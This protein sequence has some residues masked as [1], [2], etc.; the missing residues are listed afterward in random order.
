MQNV[1]RKCPVALAVLLLSAGAVSAQTSKALLRSGAEEYLTLKRTFQKMVET[2][3]IKVSPVRYQGAVDLMDCALGHTYLGSETAS[4]VSSQTR[5]RADLAYEV[6]RLKKL[7]TQLGYPESVWRPVLLAIEQEGQKK[8]DPIEGGHLERLSET[9]NAYRRQSAPSLPKT[10]IEGGCG[11][12]E[13][14]IRLATR[15]GNGQVR[16]IPVF[17]YKLC[18]VQKIDPDDPRRCDHWRE[19]AQGALLDVSGDYIYRASWPDGVKRN[20]R[21]SLTNL[22]HGQTVTI[23]KP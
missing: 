21:L 1:V 10:M 12:G 3:E 5:Q 4:H 6:V 15:P 16:L 17:F 8:F 7:I 22:E 18:E 20:G 14:G 19:P 23:S 9:L 13:V 2:G 11:E